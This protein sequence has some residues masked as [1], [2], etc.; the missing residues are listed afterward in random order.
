MQSFRKFTSYSQFFFRNQL[1]LQKKKKAV[2]LEREILRT[3]KQ[4]VKTI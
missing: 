3:M 1:D 4:R 2:N